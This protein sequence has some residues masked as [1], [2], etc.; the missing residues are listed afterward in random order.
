MTSTRR[1]LFPRMIE[2]HR[3][4]RADVTGYRASGVGLLEI[5]SLIEVARTIEVV[6]AA[7][8]AKKVNT[9]CT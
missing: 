2:A 3:Q 1:Q 7:K 5:I 8:N 9:Q 6:F 4:H